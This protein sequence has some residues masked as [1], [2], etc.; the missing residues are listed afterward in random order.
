MDITKKIP[1]HI[2]LFGHTDSGK[3]A[4]AEVLIQ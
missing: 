4:I 3:T 1:V 2:G